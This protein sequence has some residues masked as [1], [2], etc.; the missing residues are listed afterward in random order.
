MM[1]RSNL[2]TISLA[3]LMSIAAISLVACSKVTPNV[4]GLGSQ[5]EPDDG[6]TDPGPGPGPAPASDYRA[7]IQFA[8]AATEGFKATP[9]RGYHASLN[10]VAHE[11]E[12][13]Q[14]SVNRHYGVRMGVPSF[15]WRT[16]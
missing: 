14:K 8:P 7:R 3:I 9:V 11:P 2:S 13:I 4:H 10:V 5:Q 16:E 1:P 6:G 15:T 12:P